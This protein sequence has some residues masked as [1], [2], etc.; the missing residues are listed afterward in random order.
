MNGGRPT[1]QRTEV[2]LGNILIV[3]D[4]R[5]IAGALAELLVRSRHRIRSS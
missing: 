3:E 5:D 2:R 4:D 1:S